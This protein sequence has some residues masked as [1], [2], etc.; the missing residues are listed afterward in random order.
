MVSSSPGFLKMPF[1]FP[2]RFLPLPA[3]IGSWYRILVPLSFP[4]SLFFFQGSRVFGSFLLL[5]AL[6]LPPKKTPKK[7]DHSSQ[8]FS[9]SLFPTSVTSNMFGSLWFNPI[10]PHS[11]LRSLFWLWMTTQGNFSARHPSTLGDC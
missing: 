10:H 2:V 5:G 4:S 9:Q 8:A 3:R 1:S 6:F 7:H 11:S